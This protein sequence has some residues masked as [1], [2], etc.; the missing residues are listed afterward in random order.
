[1]VT[2]NWNTSMDY[3]IEREDVFVDPWRVPEF[4]ML[5]VFSGLIV[6]L[7]KLGEFI[8]VPLLGVRLK[9]MNMWDHK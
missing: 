2:I 9:S 1:M 7:F 6:W 4:E 5:E 3:L 8:P